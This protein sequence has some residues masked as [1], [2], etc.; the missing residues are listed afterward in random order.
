[1]S[2]QIRL[3]LSRQDFQS[4]TLSN[5]VRTDETKYLTRTWH[6]QSMQLEAVR[7]VSMSDLCF[8]V[9]GQVDNMDGT[10][11]AL[12]WADTTTNA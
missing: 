7:R 12:L 8:E 2:S 6:R 10:E 9:G 5:T 3:Q 1:M 11:R 4:R